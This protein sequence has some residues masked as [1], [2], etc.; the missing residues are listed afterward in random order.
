MPTETGIFTEDDAKTGHLFSYRLAEYIAGIFKKTLPVYDYGCGPGSYLKY[1][2]DVGF[3]HITGI[4]GTEKIQMEVPV[5]MVLKKDL[6]QKLDLKLNA[7]NV[8]C[9][10]VMEHLPKQFE[11]DFL[12]NITEHVI[13]GG[14]LVMSCAHEGQQGYGHVNCCPDWYA[15]EK[16]E[17]LGFIMEPQMTKN[18]RSVIEGHVAYL[19]E[20]L[21]VFRKI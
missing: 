5:S 2:N 4:E 20:N 17:D 1:L 21:F 16:I 19:R 13:K 14:F 6:S 12:E 9:I 18:V 7:G 15:I 11:Q 3:G 10:E 8:M